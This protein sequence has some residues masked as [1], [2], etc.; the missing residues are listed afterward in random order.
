MGR[1]L[2][3]AKT[4]KFTTGGVISMTIPFVSNEARNPAWLIASTIMLYWAPFLRDRPACPCIAGHVST[5]KVFPV[6]THH[7]K[8][9]KKD[10]DIG[11]YIYFKNNFLGSNRTA[12]LIQVISAVLCTTSTISFALMSNRCP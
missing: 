12:S 2:S 6:I 7:L 10:K 11:K 4:V 8:W 3:I 5:G 1:S 9:V